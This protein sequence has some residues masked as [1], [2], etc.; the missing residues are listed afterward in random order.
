MCSTLS[1]GAKTIAGKFL[2]LRVTKDVCTLSSLF[3]RA[4]CEALIG[5]M[6]QAPNWVVVVPHDGAEPHRS[7]QNRLRDEDRL[8]SPFQRGG[9]DG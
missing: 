5:V 1:Q 7:L 6:K 9:V 8:R 3:C 4:M 2:D